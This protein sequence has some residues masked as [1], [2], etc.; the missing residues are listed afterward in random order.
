[1][2]CTGAWAGSLL[3]GYCIWFL[4]YDLESKGLLEANQGPWFVTAKWRQSSAW[5]RLFDLSLDLLRAR[6]VKLA[7]PHHWEFGGG[8]RLGRWFAKRGAT[9]LESVYGLWI[10]A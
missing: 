7:F 5:L 3:V 9:K 2:V 1:M 6:E 4:T 8:E 10:G